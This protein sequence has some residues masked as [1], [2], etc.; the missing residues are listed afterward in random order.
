MPV[1]G[2]SHDL[3]YVMGLRKWCILYYICT[4]HRVR[5]FTGGVQYVATTAA[6]I[7]THLAYAMHLSR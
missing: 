5:L 6:Y 7:F 1:D 3:Y 4:V 2:P